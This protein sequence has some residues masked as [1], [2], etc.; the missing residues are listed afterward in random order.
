MIPRSVEVIHES[1]DEPA[2]KTTIPV[3]VEP[4]GGG[5]AKSVVLP[6]D[7][8]ANA[9]A[10]ENGSFVLTLD[11]PVTLKFRAGEVVNSENYKTL[12]LHRLN[13]RRMREIRGAAPEDFQDQL[14]AAG[15][16]MSLGRVK[17]L[18]DEMDQSDIA[19]AMVVM[20][21]FINPG[22]KTGR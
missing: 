21:F 1:P 3:L 6:P 18:I 14:F 8:P 10:A 9:V 2:E 22:R 13:G 16:E 20:R 19:A 12:H 17:L 4:D 11:Y 7:F 5:S 15:L